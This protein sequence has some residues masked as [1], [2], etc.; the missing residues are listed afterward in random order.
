MAEK[1]TNGAFTSN[2]NGWSNIG[3]RAFTWVAGRARGTSLGTIERYL[4]LR[5]GF[6]KYGQVLS[7]VISASVWYSSVD[8]VA[9]TGSNRF[10]IELDIPGGG[11][12]ILYE[13][14]FSAED[15]SDAVLD[16]MDVAPY[17]TNNGTYY[18]RLSLY[19]Q[20][21][22]TGG[23]VVQDSYGEY[24]NISLLVVEKFTH[25]VVEV[26]GGAETQQKKQSS[27]LSSILRFIESLS[28]VGGG[29]IAGT[30][31]MVQF[32]KAG[33]IEIIGKV[34]KITITEALGAVESLARSF[35]FCHYDIPTNSIG[36][37]ESMSARVTAGNITKIVTR[38]DAGT[39]WTERVP[40]ETDWEQ[41][42]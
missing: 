16:S 25:T 38:F 14:T 10:C 42:R 41:T 28:H 36:L 21:G 22:V 2:L 26:L 20:A 29:D 39:Q 8:G 6:T 3:S 23:F 24:D 35:G 33:L 37:L 4:C 1:L 34:V 32:E 19:S 40:V 11:S 9:I 30:Q 7:A 12:V 5:Q 18:L 27:I 31:S 15:G 17:L 13:S